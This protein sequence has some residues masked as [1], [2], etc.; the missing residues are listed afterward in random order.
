MSFDALAP[1]YSWLEI[2]LAG[3]RLRRAR[4]TWLAE[5]SGCERILIAGIGH[6]HFLRACARFLPDAEIV[7][8]DAS[9]AMLRHA[10]RRAERQAPASQR[11]KFVHASLPKWAPPPGTFDA[12]VTPFFLDCFAPTTL[13][14]VIRVLAN[15][16]RPQRAHWLVTD[17]M[18]PERGWRRHRARAIHA[19]MYAFFRPI[20]GIQAQRVTPPDD[21]LRA[22]GFVL[23]NRRYY[24]A[25]LIH[26]DHWI[27]CRE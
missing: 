14:E 25:Q 6:G 23:A 19:L 24:D 17:F 2:A 26:A 5:L 16:A 1:H 13:A 4:L 20:T 9:A 18:V 10:Q 7:G 22:Q 11:L 21:L 3:R 27:R 15:A 12:I 8:V